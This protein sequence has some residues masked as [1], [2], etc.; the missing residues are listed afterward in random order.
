V[1]ILFGHDSNAEIDAYKN[2]VEA[3]F[4]ILDFKEYRNAAVLLVTKNG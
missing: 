1:W 4:K 2:G 3:N